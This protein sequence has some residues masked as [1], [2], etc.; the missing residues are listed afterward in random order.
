[1]ADIVGN[2][3]AGYRFRTLLRLHFLL[4]WRPSKT[5]KL[6]ENIGKGVFILLFAFLGLLLC[7]IAFTMTYGISDPRTQVEVAVGGGAFLF[8]F[9]LFVAVFEEGL[10]GG[11][12]P[13][14]LFHLPVSPRQ[15]L[16]SGLLARMAGPL[17]LP[18]AGFFLGCSFAMAAS[19]SPLRA[20]M[21]LAG[22]VLWCFQAFL[23]L[24]AADYVL[25][26]LRRSRRFVEITGMVGFLLFMG[27]FLL[28]NY[29]FGSTGSANGSTFKTLGP[30]LLS[31]WH[32]L[33]FIAY[34][35]PGAAPVAWIGTGWYGLVVLSAALL[36]CLALL[37][38]GS[39]LLRR[40]M[41]T[42]AG[43]ARRRKT[44]A[45][46]APGRRRRAGFLQDLPFWPYLYKE[47]RYLVRDTNMKMLLLQTLIGPFFL[48]IIFSSPGHSRFTA[49]V[50][51]VGLPLLFLMYLG[52][53]AFNQ[54]AMERDGVL[55]TVLSPLP[56]WRLFAGKN[57]LYFLF[58]ALI[59]VPVT[60]L[61]V[62]KGIG[63]GRIAADWAAYLPLG[64]IFLGAGNLASILMPIPVVP[65]GR[66]LRP[67][68]PQGQLFLVMLLRLALNAAIMV[69]ALP[70]LLG[71]W[72]FLHFGKAPLPAAAFVFGMVVYGAVVYGILLSISSRIMPSREPKIYE[73]FIREQD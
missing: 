54:I 25:Y 59:L 28:Q 14:L 24:M 8:F 69:V 12:D 44:S 30:Q 5:G 1:M 70:L 6:A 19:G 72:A 20:V 61:L 27:W 41:E 16:V 64:L 37:M 66:R 58:Y 47:F 55:S 57:C 53:L 26:H 45:H 60:V 18:P 33:K 46:K 63:A 23:V 42:G 68:L 13:S 2:T 48:I 51:E 10:G 65:R 31:A 39:W 40:L 3:P 32:Y 11:I 67:R 52:P 73:I 9:F 62:Y 43:S 21:T 22:A 38:A 4:A 15:I 71:R 56:R 7:G 50:L 35:L 29:L 49:G 36:E 34:L 17:L